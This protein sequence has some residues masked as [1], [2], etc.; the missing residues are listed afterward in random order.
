MT[1]RFFPD[2]M[3][4]PAVS[5]ETVGW[6][7]AAARRSLVVQR[8]ARCATTRH[9]PGPLCP[10]CRST[11]AEWFELPG[12]GTVFT[13][14]VVHQAFLPALAER[15]PYVVA[16]VDLDGIE[17]NAEDEGARFVSNLVEIDPADVT[18]GMPVS[19]VWEEMGP[20]LVVPR[21]RPAAGTTRG[22]SR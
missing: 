6:W 17:R 13:F 1:V 9:P 16:A 2:E 22:A 4:V 11:A 15:L 5:A 21:F 7:E 19:V 14:T 3:P 20:E 18:I 8:C 12:T 10:R